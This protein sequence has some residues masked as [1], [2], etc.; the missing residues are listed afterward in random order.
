MRRK[1]GYILQKDDIQSV[2]FRAQKGRAVLSSH[3]N[4]PVMESSASM[5]DEIGTESLLSQEAVCIILPLL[6]LCE[7]K[8]EGRRIHMLLISCIYYHMIRLGEIIT[9]YIRS[10]YFCTIAF[11]LK[12]KLSYE[13]E[14]C[15]IIRLIICHIHAHP[16]I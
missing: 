12:L 7:E 9:L 2:T 14:M 10:S 16:L 8:K 11:L 3:S 4:E 13:V 5:M 15:L 6:L 1:S